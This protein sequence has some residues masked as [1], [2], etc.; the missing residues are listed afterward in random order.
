MLKCVGIFK[1]VHRHFFLFCQKLYLGRYKGT[2]N[3]SVIVHQL[4]N[5][6]GV[7]SRLEAKSSVKR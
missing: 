5:D 6:F 1:W 3:G 7:I 2:C 4:T